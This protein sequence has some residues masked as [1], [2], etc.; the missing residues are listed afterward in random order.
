MTP[1][2]PYQPAS[3]RLRKTANWLAGILAAVATIMLAGSQL[4]SIGSISFARDPWR[5]VAAVA[6]SLIVVVAVA[7][8]VSLLISIQMPSEG[9]LGPIRAAASN[10]NSSLAKLVAED[11]G[12]RDGRTTLTEFLDDYEEAR[13]DLH[14]AEMDVRSATI[15]AR[16]SLGKSAH[17]KA[18]ATLAAA[19]VRKSDAKAYIDE[20]RPH[21]ITLAQL[22][23]YLG[24]RDRLLAARP[25]ILFAALAAA[26][27]L[28][29]FAW[30]VNPPK[31]EAGAASAIQQ[32]PSVGRLLLT[33]AGVTQLANVLGHNCVVSAGTR[34]GV[35]VIVLAS[36]DSAFDIIVIPKGPCAE[37]IR[38]TIS[39]NLGRVVSAT[40]IPVP[41]S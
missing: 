1:G 13:E 25:R 41:R 37:P 39:P 10:L 15:A 30:A 29:L 28:V 20:M 17:E 14:Q 3:D 16:G 38:V 11:S 26:S 9:S 40:S 12:L 33:P 36:A 2:N 7:Y 5:L 27:F 22:S 18:D 32:S 35:A 23:S 6:S 34:A 8:D 19:K 4:S 31:L 21:M 24:L